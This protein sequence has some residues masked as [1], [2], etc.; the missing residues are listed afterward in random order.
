MIG[1]GESET[2]RGREV[3]R[4]GGEGAGE[5]TAEGEGREDGDFGFG[6]RTPSKREGLRVGDFRFRLPCGGGWLGRGAAGLEMGWSGSSSGPHVR[7]RVCS[8]GPA[9]HWGRQARAYFF[10]GSWTFE[11][12]STREMTSFTRVCFD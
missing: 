11:S 4:A 7:E 8:A 12:S 2:G 1:E 6:G 9:C 5:V 3:K 10:Y